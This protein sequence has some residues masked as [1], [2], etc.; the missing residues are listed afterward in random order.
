MQRLQKPKNG[1]YEGAAKLDTAI[2]FSKP[3][4]MQRC[5]VF[6]RGK[7]GRLCRCG[8]GLGGKVRRARGTAVVTL[9][10]GAIVISPTVS[11]SGRRRAVCLFPNYVRRPA[12]RAGLL[13]PVGGGFF[14]DMQGCVSR[15]KYVPMCVLARVISWECWVVF[16]FGTTV[17]LLEP[18][19]FLSF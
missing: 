6:R 12:A 7:A 13:P 14:D 9:G 4:R 18:L 16:D 8:G 15:V 3:S 11:R 1:V 19:G 17:P 2:L 5:S 10:P